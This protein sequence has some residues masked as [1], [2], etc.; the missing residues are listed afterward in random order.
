MIA[1][2]IGNERFTLDLEWSGQVD[3]VKQPLRDWFVD[4]KVA[5]RTRSSHGFTYA[6]VYGGGHLVHIIAPSSS[7]FVLMSFRSLMISL[8]KHWHFYSVGLREKSFRGWG[9][10]V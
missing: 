4:G 1:N 7:L 9:A 3:F 6:S 8:R 10:H 2:H 5:G